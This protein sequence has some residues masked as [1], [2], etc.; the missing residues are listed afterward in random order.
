MRSK[1]DRIR[2]LPKRK[3]TGAWNTIMNAPNVN[4]LSALA[5]ALKST[6]DTEG[7]YE[8]EHKWIFKMNL[9]MNIDAFRSL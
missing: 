8:K 4:L 1:F 3:R 7:L 5:I 6:P 2:C 9:A